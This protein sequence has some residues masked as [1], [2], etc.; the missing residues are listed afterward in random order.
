MVVAVAVVS[1]FVAA[2]VGRGTAQAEAQLAQD[3]GWGQSRGL[4][5]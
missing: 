1:V 5:T 2:V 3:T 4:G